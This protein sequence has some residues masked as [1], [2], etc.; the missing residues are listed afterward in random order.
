V[1]AAFDAAGKGA[2]GDSIEL[3]GDPAR[4]VT[5]ADPDAAAYGVRFSAGTAKDRSVLAL[6]EAAEEVAEGDIHVT[7]AQTFPL[8]EA[9]EAAR[10][11][12][13]GHARG[14]LVLLVD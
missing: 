3:T 8:A 1:D 9:A 10:L 5:I 12:D 11:S 7:V 2:L 4:V 6:R 14:K 13:A